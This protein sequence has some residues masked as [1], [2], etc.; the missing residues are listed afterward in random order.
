MVVKNPLIKKKTIKGLYLLESTGLDHKTKFGVQI[1]D[2]H[3]RLQSDDDVF[4]YR[5]LN[6]TCESF[7]IGDILSY[8]CIP[9]SI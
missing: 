2:L 8:M 6:K 9:Q 5:K 7:I 4:Y 1:V 3:K